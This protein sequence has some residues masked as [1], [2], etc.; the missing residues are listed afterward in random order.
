MKSQR[1]KQASVVSVSLANSINRS[2]TE[3]CV[4]YHE[5]ILPRG[6]R[7]VCGGCGSVMWVSEKELTVVV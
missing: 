2:C 7:N 4:L 6:L 1:T 3:S 5:S